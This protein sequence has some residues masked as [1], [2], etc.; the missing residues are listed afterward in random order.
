MA[1]SFSLPSMLCF[2]LYWRVLLATQVF[3]EKQGLSRV[4]ISTAGGISFLRKT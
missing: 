2:V 3:S 4:L 1:N